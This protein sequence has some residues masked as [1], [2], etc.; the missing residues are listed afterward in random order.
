MSVTTE[1]FQAALTKFLEGKKIEDVKKG[2]VRTA[3]S[4]EFNVPV[5]DLKVDPLKSAL[6]HALD[7]V[8][9]QLTPS[10]VAQ[11]DDEGITPAAPAVT[12]A[13]PAA[14]TPGRAAVVATPPPAAAVS[15][16]SSSASS[17]LGLE[18]P[19]AKRYAGNWGV[20]LGRKRIVSAKTWAG[21][22]MID[23]REW[24]TKDGDPELKPGK[25]GISLSVDEWKLLKSM[26]GEIDQALEEQQ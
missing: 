9:N 22:K 19:I 3:M 4:A 21:K 14:I 23:I 2:Q 5:P 15:R 8:V 10:A 17:G 16:T 24:Y 7:V 20:E 6:D 11:D 1:Q 12:M 26:M 13:P 25:K 18:K